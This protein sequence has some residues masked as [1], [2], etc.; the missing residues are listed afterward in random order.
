[1]SQQA[2][3]VLNA[4]VQPTGEVISGRATVVRGIPE[5]AS[6]IPS[7]TLVTLGP[8]VRRAVR[9]ELGATEGEASPE[10]RERQRLGAMERRGEIELGRGG[11]P[12]G[13]W[14]MPAPE[15][16]EGLVRQALLEDRDSGS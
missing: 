13:F 14:D 10:Q 1:M 15:D 5:A 16:P 9:Q 7:L 8:M 2:T 4:R 11:M 3:Y 6:Q 12:E